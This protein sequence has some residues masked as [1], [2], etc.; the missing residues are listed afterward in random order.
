MKMLKK[1]IT[2]NWAYFLVNYLAIFLVFLLLASYFR[3]WVLVLALVEA[4]HIFVLFFFNNA[5]I[6]AFSPLQ[7]SFIVTPS[8]SFGTTN[9]FF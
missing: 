6:P 8:V 9:V 4:I 5:M 3:P 7:K 2:S 1:R